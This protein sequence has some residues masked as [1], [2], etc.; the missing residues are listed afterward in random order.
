MTINVHTR[1]PKFCETRLS[2]NNFNIRQLFSPTDLSLR[3][4]VLSHSRVTVN[5]RRSVRFRC[6]KNLKP[7]SPSQKVISPALLT[8]NFLSYAVPAVRGGLA[9]AP[10]SGQFETEII[11]TA[12][13]LRECGKYIPSGLCVYV[14]MCNGSVQRKRMLSTGTLRRNLRMFVVRFVLG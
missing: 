8:C 6:N 11:T 9:A 1:T 12:Y 13:T 4:L 5:S 7:S 14:Q 10:G 2:C 3:M